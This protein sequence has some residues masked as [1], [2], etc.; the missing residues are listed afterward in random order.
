MLPA[1][2]S[3]VNSWNT[4]H[5]HI[6]SKFMNKRDIANPNPGR[7]EGTELL[8]RDRARYIDKNVEYN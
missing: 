5:D 8:Y 7:F 4:Q 1:S 6:S 2:G 3:V